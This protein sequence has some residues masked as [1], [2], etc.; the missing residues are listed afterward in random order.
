MQE[1]GENRFTFIV[2]SDPESRSHGGTRGHLRLLHG[3]CVDILFCR[4]RNMIRAP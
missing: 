3:A 1:H 4:M 2:L